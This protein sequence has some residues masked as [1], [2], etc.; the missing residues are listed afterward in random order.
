MFITRKHLI[1]IAAVFFLLLALGI[2]LFR[3]APQV[4]TRVESQPEPAKVE[5]KPEHRKVEPKPAPA[6]KPE[7]VQVQ[8][9]PFSRQLTVPANI[10]WFDSGIEVTGKRVKIE[11]RSGQWRN[12]P[13]SGANDGNGRYPYAEQSSLVLPSA[14]L[15]SLIGRTS[16]GVFFVGNLYEGVPG[17]GRLYLAINDKSGYY[18]DNIGSLTVV[19]S[20]VE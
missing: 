4:I 16:Q 18:S 13:S 5:S 7:K 9:L 17:D 12:H 20:F 2:Y 11:Y 14:N 3:P 1:F 6:P 10:E 15:S 8:A 19:V